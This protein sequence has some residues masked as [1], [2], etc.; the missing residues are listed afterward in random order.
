MNTGKIIIAFVTGAAVGAVL[1]ILFAPEKG[2]EIRQKVA[3][4]AKDLADDIK[5]KVETGIGI[6]SG[7]KD[8]IV[9]RYEEVS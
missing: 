6:A 1:G 2:S 8:K 5:E 4:S 7:W 3:D 9:S